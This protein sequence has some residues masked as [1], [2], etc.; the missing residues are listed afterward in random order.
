MLTA[1]PAGAITSE[2]TARPARCLVVAWWPTVETVGGWWNRRFDPEID[3]VGADRAPVADTVS[4]VGSIK[5]L[6]SPL[7]HH[8]L[9]A[10]CRAAVEVP[11][12]DP[13]T[14]GLVLASLSG[15]APD[16]DLTGCSLWTPQDLVDSWA[17]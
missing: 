5:W 14:T 9:T 4:F 10:L 6:V 1:R 2:E 17:G 12:F 15:V 8:D 13:G 11:G 16:L 7:D 3:L